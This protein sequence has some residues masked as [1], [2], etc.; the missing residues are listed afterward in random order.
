MQKRGMAL[1]KRVSESEVLVRNSAFKWT[2]AWVLFFI[3]LLTPAIFC[4]AESQRQT[5]QGGE[6]VPVWVGVVLLLFALLSCSM[7]LPFTVVTT[8]RMDK[9]GTDAVCATS[10]LLARHAPSV[11]NLSLCVC[12]LD[13]AACPCTSLVHPCR[14]ALMRQCVD[15]LVS[16]SVAFSSEIRRRRHF[17]AGPWASQLPPVLMYPDSQVSA[18]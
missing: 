15:R 11:S 8:T 17:C 4:L 5:A 3:L 1:V 6:I 10:S 13:R 2:L 9:S 16:D 12:S 18:V 7:M 14:R